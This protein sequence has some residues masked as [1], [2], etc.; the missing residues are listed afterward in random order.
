MTDRIL[1]IDS[2]HM[3]DFLF[4]RVVALFNRGGVIGYPTETVYGLGGDATN[5]NVI[6]RIF[7]LKGRDSKKPLLCLVHSK[8]D[9]FPIIEQVSQKAERL[10]DT[11]W[12]GPLTLI[13]SIS[14]KLPKSLQSECGK[15]GIRISNDP[16][17]QMLTQKFKNPIVSTSAN[18]TGQEPARTANQVINTFGKSLDLV[19]DGGKRDS[20]NPSTVLDVTEDPPRVIRKGAVSLKKIQK[21]L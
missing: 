11:F 12:P 9:L 14:K 17:C 21:L 7:Q 15:I 4:D 18:R 20:L 8:E 16:I 6:H 1:K 2:E 13:F 3:E 5:E 10:M 19:L